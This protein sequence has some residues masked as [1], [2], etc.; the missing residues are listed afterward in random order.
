MLKEQ[1]GQDLAEHLVLQFDNTCRESRNQFML[2]FSATCVSKGL[3]R[4]ISHPFFRV[5]HTH[6]CVDQ[7]FVSVAR[8][9]QNAS[10]Q[11]PEVGRAET[12]SYLIL[13]PSSRCRRRRTMAPCKIS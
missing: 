1:T 3:F 2:L 8:I 5:G 10:L 12:S 6:F 11:T 4:S 13:G 9:L 7:R